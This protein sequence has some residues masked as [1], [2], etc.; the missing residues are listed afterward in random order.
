MIGPGA[1]TLRPRGLATAARA[2]ALVAA[3]LLGAC[4]RSEG[5]A[6]GL[7][8]RDSAG[9]T[10]LESR[11]PAWSGGE[12]WSVAVEPSL[13]I[14]VVDGEPAY[15][16][17]RVRGAATAS[18]GRIVVANG[19][20]LEVRVYDSTGRH[21]TSFGGPGEGPGEFRSF[22]SLILLGDT[23]AVFDHVAQRLTRFDLEGNMLRTT[24]FES[25]DDPVH[26]LRMYALGGPVAG[27]FAMLVRA[28]PADMR[29]EP[30]VYWDTLPTLRYARDGTLVDTIGEFAGMD[31][32]STPRRAGLV[33]FGR[34]SSGHVHDGLLYQTDGG[35]Y[36]VRVHDPERGLVRIL[37]ALEEPR[38]VTDE[39]LADYRAA[40]GESSTDAEERRQAEEAFDEA[41]A[42]RPR[43]ETLP[44]IAGIVV[45][46]HG[47]VWVREYQPR[48]DRTPRRW[49][50]FEV[51][52]RWLGRVRMPAGF[53]PTEIGP[54]HLLGVARDELGVEYVR[55][56][57]LRRGA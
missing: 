23:V 38:P 42:S 26:P 5:P 33:T 12:S 41:M 25:T 19:G 51:D 48:F 13:S 29:P 17:A 31:T 45:D 2:P 40:I 21:L 46:A 22:G 30:V 16:L 37:R 20:S 27:G 57:A 55:R 56:Y 36:E 43:R 47:H 1:S 24:P 3:V 53:T 14:G 34:V 52:G 28:F 7:V 32:Y 49:G 15:Q 44:W 4:D 35:R 10:I 6:D 39:R 8:T 18:D 50:V 11:G 54:E 9:V